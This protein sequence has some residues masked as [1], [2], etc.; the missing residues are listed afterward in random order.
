M[1][2]GNTDIYNGYFSCCTGKLNA[3]GFRWHA[4][5]QSGKWIVNITWGRSWLQTDAVVDD[6][7]DLVAV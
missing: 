4:A 7:G 6:F 1:S 3:C 5:C 2:Y